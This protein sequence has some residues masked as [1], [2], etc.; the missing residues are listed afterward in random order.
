MLQTLLLCLLARCGRDEVKHE[1]VA[2]AAYY[3]HKLRLGQKEIFHLEAFVAR[4][5]FLLK[6]AEL[7]AHLRP[8]ATV[9]AVGSA[10]RPSAVIAMDD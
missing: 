7:E 6:K 8:A 1:L 5:L 9:S 4:A 10:G 3:E 2:W